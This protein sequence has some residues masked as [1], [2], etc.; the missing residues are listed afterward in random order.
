MVPLRIARLVEVTE[1]EGPGARFALWVQGCPLRCPGCCNA[2][3]LPFGL[4]REVAIADLR[5][6]IEAARGR[7]EGVTWCGGEPFAQ[8]APLAVLS[9]DVRAMGLSVVVFS[10]YTLEE[11][12]ASDEP[13]V[14]D[15]LAATDLLIDGR[16]EAAS[17]E[18]HR[19]WAGSSNQ[20]FH[21]LTDRYAPGIERASPG[22]PLRTIEIVIGA[23]GTAEANG[24]PEWGT[25]RSPRGSR[26]RR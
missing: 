23:D 19:K 24:W 10:G 18:C 17:P 15:L 5:D 1:A 4:G 9:R 25:S 26:M 2:E 8:A 13:G 6:A 3:L 21:F 20:R 7:I 16:Y 22:E 14:K 12:R 11:L